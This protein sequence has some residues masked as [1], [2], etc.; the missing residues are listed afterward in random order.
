[1]STSSLTD[2]QFSILIKV[3][4]RTLEDTEFGQPKLGSTELFITKNHVIPRIEE[5]IAKIKKKGLNVRGDGSQP[6]RPIYKSNFSVKPD[7]EI[8][9]YGE[10]LIAVEVKI[11][12]KKDPT[13]S[14]SKA[15][16]Q[17]LLY[18]VWGYKA[19][20]VLVFDFRPGKNVKTKKLKS[21]ISDLVDNLYVYIF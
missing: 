8:E 19:V 10:R 18:R 4:S 15:I 13:G 11:L 2:K 17:G 6:V 12:K 14:L 21:R 3:I 16:G 9:N 20:F 1:M 7:I 5:V